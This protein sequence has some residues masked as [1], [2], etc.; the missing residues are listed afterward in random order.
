M[1]KCPTEKRCGGG[2]YYTHQSPK[3]D[4]KIP[5]CDMRLIEHNGLLESIMP[6]LTF[7]WKTETLGFL[8]NH[9][10]LILTKHLSPNIKWLHE[11]KLKDFLSST[12][13]IRRVLDLESEVN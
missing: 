11:Q 9:V 6:I 13:Q 12:Y 1:R 7:I 3:T 2:G 5:W 4:R 8:Y 10:L